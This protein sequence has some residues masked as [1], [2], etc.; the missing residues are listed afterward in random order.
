MADQPRRGG[1]RSARIFRALLA[2]YPSQFRDEYGR[3]MA[4][5]FADRY[6]D[7]R[8]GWERARIW[9]LAI[10]GL[11]VEA[12]KEHGG[13]ARQDVRDALR[14]FRRHPAHAATVILTLA[15]GIGANTAM[16][17]VVKGVILNPLPYT[18]PDAL[19]SLYTRF[20][21]SS[22]YDFPY[23][24]LS[25]PELVDLREQVSALSISA[26]FE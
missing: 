20:V 11:I 17:S 22:G 2:V 21:P 6:R 9:L 12:P 4:M 18:N 25:G 23:F 10:G 15:I 19:V 5:V 7:A 24:S 8:S 3:E 26:Y 16:F 14:T 13:L 1:D